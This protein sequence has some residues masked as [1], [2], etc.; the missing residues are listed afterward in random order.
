M[1]RLISAS[2][3]MIF[4]TIAVTV[5]FADVKDIDPIDPTSSCERFLDY[6]G[7][8]ECLSL[9]KR[10]DDSYLV[11]LCNQQFSNSGFLDCLEESLDLPKL[12][13]K[14]IS[15]CNQEQFSDEERTQCVAGLSNNTAD[16]SRMPASAT[17]KKLKK[18]SQKHKKK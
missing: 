9:T 16:N 17:K 4:I 3:G 2:I 15:E 10:I 13:P 18:T 12:S 14:K 7:Q 11:S 8:E 1:I 6:V 5:A